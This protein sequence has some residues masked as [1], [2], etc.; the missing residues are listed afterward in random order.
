M[1]LQ[2][3]KLDDVESVPKFLKESTTFNA[4][5]EYWTEQLFERVMR[6]FIWENTNEVP[7]KEIEQ[8]LILA[9]HCG[10]TKDKKGQ[11]TAFFGKFTGVTKYYDEWLEYVYH[12][13]VETG[14]RTIGKDIVIVNNNSLRNPIYPLIHHYA[15]LLAH[16]DVSLVMQ[17]VNSRQRGVPIAMYNNQKKSIMTYLNKLY[18]GQLDAITDPAGAGVNYLSI[19]AA[20]SESIVNLQQTK[21]KILKSFYTDIGVR[22]AFEKRSNAVES[23][24]EADTPLLLL[25]ISDMI[26]AR[27]Q[28]CEEVNAMFGTNWTVQVNPEIQVMMEND[29]KEEEADESNS[30]RDMEE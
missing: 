11:L 7:A 23:E 27:E 22:S 30:E 17:F 15:T 21:E 16:N 3:C 24:V 18:N 2:R 6:L 9:G 8:R 20:G 13:P 29:T 5:Y 25:N 19:S 26:S 4:Y 14:T 1:F 10:I 28:A 12:S